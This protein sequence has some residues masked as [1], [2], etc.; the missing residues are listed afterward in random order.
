M[1]AALRDIADLDYVVLRPAMVY[2]LGDKAGLGAYVLTLKQRY[3]LVVHV[4][5]RRGCERVSLKQHVVPT[6]RG[7]IAL[8]QRDAW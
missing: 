4:R 5:I 8:F 2:G 7:S 6:N 3:Y 1:E